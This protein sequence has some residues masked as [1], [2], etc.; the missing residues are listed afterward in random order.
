MRIGEL[1]QRT[2]V[3]ARSLRYYEQ[4]GLV[5]STRSEGGQRHYLAA[6][7]ERVELIRQLFDAGLN[8]KV[9]AR[10]LPCVHSDDAAVIEDAFTTMVSERDRLTAGIARLADARDALDVLIEANTRYRR[11]AGSSC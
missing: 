11:G 10:L 4:Q 2:G 6:E 9:I 1:A 8:S 3:S 7:V 5:R